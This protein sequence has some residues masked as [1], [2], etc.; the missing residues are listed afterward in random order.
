MYNI[1]NVKES[2]HLFLIFFYDSDK[3]GVLVSIYPA[4]GQGSN[5]ITFKVKKFFNTEFH[6]VAHRVTLSNAEKLAG[7]CHV[8]SLLAMTVMNMEQ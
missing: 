5:G 2:I 7:D 4:S 8:V 3:E 6:G 1:H